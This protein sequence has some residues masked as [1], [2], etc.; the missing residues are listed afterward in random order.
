MCVLVFILILI[1][2]LFVHM[3]NKQET[4]CVECKYGLVCS[5]DPAPCDGWGGFL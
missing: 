2:L 1:V 3:P 4:F 5:D